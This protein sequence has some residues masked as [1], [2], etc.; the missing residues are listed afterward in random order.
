MNFARSYAIVG[1]VLT[2]IFWAGNIYVSKVLVGEI[3]PIALNFSRW[4]IAVLLL[5]PFAYRQTVNCWDKIKPAFIPLCIYGF[6]GVTVYNSLLY[7]SAYT[8]PGINIALISTLTPLLT[9]IATWLFFGIAPTKWQNIGFLLGISG[10]LLLLS[11]GELSQ[12]LAL[13]FK[14]G[15]LWMLLA[16]AAWAIYT[17]YLVKKPQGIPALVFLY[18]TTLI[19]VILALPTLIWEMQQS[20]NWAYHLNWHNVVALIYIGIFPSVLSYLFFNH[21]VQQLGPQVASLCLYLLLQVFI[22][23]L[24]SSTK[25]KNINDL[26]YLFETRRFFYEMCF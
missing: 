16:C 6:L 4:L 24:I 23:F 1:L 12:L 2:S 25:K 14:L 7:T 9:F 3:S 11:R 18:I 10:V 26:I 19:G 21:G 20:S 22:F 8:T 5:T 13:N 17:A 15:D